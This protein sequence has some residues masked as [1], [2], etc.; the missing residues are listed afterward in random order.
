MN[1]PRSLTIARHG[2]AFGLISPLLRSGY[3]LTVAR[4]PGFVSTSADGSQKAFFQQRPIT[5]PNTTGA[6]AMQ[7]LG[8]GCRKQVAPRCALETPQR[9]HVLDEDGN[10]ESRALQPDPS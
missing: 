7:S 1:G 3:G 2:T 9:L 6:F 10:R 5:G 4:L 8:I